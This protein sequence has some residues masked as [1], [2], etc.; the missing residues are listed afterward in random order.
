MR[1]PPSLVLRYGTQ[2]SWGA[3]GYGLAALISGFVYDAAGGSH[4]GLMVVYVT[5]LALAL[6]A[7]VGVPVGR[8]DE[9]AGGQDDEEP[10]RYVLV[11]VIRNDRGR[12]HYLVPSTSDRA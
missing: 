7:A 8:T 10:W 2:R 9:P 5:V 4:D 12:T 11:C 6:L 1:R 3:A